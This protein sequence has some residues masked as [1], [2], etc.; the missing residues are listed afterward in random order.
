MFTGLARH[1]YSFKAKEG[2]RTTVMELKFSRPIDAN[3]YAAI[4]RL[5]NR[6][7]LTAEDMINFARFAA[8]QMI[9]VESHF[10]RLDV[11]LTAM[12]E[13]SVKRMFKH[14]KEFKDRVTTRP[15]I[16]L[17]CG[18]TLD[19]RQGNERLIR[20]TFAGRGTCRSITAC[21]V[22]SS[23]RRCSRTTEEMARATS[24]SRSISRKVTRCTN[25]LPD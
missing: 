25:E 13:E 11:L 21:S 9:R 16:Q 4:E 24:A 1:F 7:E 5:L 18:Y 23:D 3:G 14:H 10:D 22:C 2:T 6:A 12:L 17:S 20:A 15:I 8:A 19:V